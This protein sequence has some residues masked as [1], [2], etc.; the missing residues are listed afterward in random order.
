MTGARSGLGSADPRTRQEAERIPTVNEPTRSEPEQKLPVDPVSAGP[1]PAARGAPAGRASATI[2][3]GFLALIACLVLFG[4]IAEG[5][6]TSEIF[7]LDTLATPFLHGLANPTLDAL[8]NGATFAGSDL[9]LVPAFVVAIVVLVRIGRPGGALFLTV[10][11]GGS[12]LVNAA[13]KLLFQ[14]PR[15]SVPWAVAPSDYS[16]PSGHTMNSVAFYVALA[17][18][19]WSIRGRRPGTIAVVLAAALSLLIGVSRIYLGYHYFTDVL[20][21]ILAGISWLL[22]VLAAFRT[23]PMERFWFGSNARPNAVPGAA[24]R[25]PASRPAPSRAGGPRAATPPRDPSP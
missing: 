11:S 2:F 6:R 18:I 20:G 19:V 7:T 8:M 21:G 22:I 10:A 1:L 16:F 25:T 24:R 12:L 23:R 3:A 5:L 9:T 13:M 4:T 15:P 14:R 17:I